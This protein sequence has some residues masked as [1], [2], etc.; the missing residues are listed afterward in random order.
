[1]SKRKYRLVL[2]WGIALAALMVATSGFCSEKP[3]THI[4]I[5]SG[6]TGGSWYPLG[7]VLADIIS[8]DVGIK[9]TVDIGGGVENI[10]RIDSGADA[11]VGF[12]MTPALIDG[13]EGRFPFKKPH[14]DVRM[15]SYMDGQYV[16]FVALKKSGIKSWWDL[17]GKKISPGSKGLG[18]EVLTQLIL[19]EMG[20]SYETI[21]QSGFRHA[22]RPARCQ[23]CNRRLS[24]PLFRGASTHQGYCSG[25]HGYQNP[26]PGHKEIPCLQRF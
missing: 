21:T 4:I 17:K 23:Y 14:K 12:G 11:Q 20:W 3:V 18:V 24:P 15:I 1:M 10:K 7:G 16:Q 19:K 9:T 22:G 8:K 6:P 5:A 26:G 13:R 25:P 2:A